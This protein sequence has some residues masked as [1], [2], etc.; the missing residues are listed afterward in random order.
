[1][2]TSTPIG[3]QTTTQYKTNLKKHNT[4]FGYRRSFLETISRYKLADIGSQVDLT[5]QPD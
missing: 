1:M 2:G 5:G 3:V 4:S